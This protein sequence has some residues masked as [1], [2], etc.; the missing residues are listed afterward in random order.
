MLAHH[1][2]GTG[3]T[4]TIV[5]HTTTTTANRNTWRRG[6]REREEGVGAT[7]VG[8]GDGFLNLAIKDPSWPG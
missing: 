6:Q 4:N 1:L 3:D 2:N 7:P 8:R 5:G